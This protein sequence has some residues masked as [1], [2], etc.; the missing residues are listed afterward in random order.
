MSSLFVD[1]HNVVAILE[2]SDAAEGFEQIIDF[3]SGSYIHYALTNQ[4]G[5]LSTHTTRF[6]SLALTQKVFAN[7]R[8]VGKGFLRV[9]TPLFEGMIADRPP[10]EEELGAEQVH[11]DAVVVAVV[12]E[13]VVEDVAHMA[14]PSPPPHGISSPPQE[15]S[16]PPYQPP[17]LPQPQDAEGSSLLFQQVLDICYALA[18]RVEGLENDKA[19]QQLEIVRL[20]ARVKKL[21][22]IHMV[23]SSKFRRLK[24]VGTSQRVESLEDMENVFNQGRIIVD[25]DRDEE[26]ELVADQEKDA[27]V[28]GRHAD[29]QAELYNLD[30]DHSSKVL[31]MQE[32][33]TEVQ[34]AVE[35]VTTA[36]LMT[37]VVTAAATQVVAAS[38]PIP[39]AKP[40]IL[41]IAAAPAVSTRRRKGVVIRD[42]KEELPSN[43]PAENPKVKDKGKRILIEVPKPIK[44]KDQIEMD[45]EYVRKLQEEFNKEHEET[46]K[47]IDWNVAFDHV[48]SKEPQYIKRYHGMKKKPQT[49]SE[50]R[51]NMIFYLKN[52][53]GYKMDFFKGMKYDEI[54]PIFQAKFDA[55]MRFLF[56]SREEMEEEDQEII[57]SIN[58]TPAQK[59]AKR[60]KLSEE[61][62][63]ADDLRK[64][65]EIV[66]D[67]D[68]DVFVE[69]TPLAQKVPVMDYHMVVIDNKPRNQKSVHGLALVKRWKLMTS[70]GVHVITLLTVQ[71]FLLVEK[72]YPL[73]RFTLEQLV[74]VA[75]LQVDEEKLMLPSE[76]K[77]CQSKIDAARLKLKLFKNITAAE[78]ITK[79]MSI[80]KDQQQALDD[81]L[82]PRNHHLRIGNSYKTY[83]DFASRKAIPKLK[84]VW[85]STREK[86]VQAPKASPGQRLKTTTKV[87]KFG[88]KNLHATIPKAKG[89]ETLSEVALSEDEQM[90]IATK[91]SKIQFHSS[92]VS[93]SSH[94]VDTQS[95][96]PDEQQQKTFSQDEEDA[97]EE[98]D[99]NDDSQESKSDNDGDDLIYPNLSTYKVDNEEEEEEKADD[100]DDDSQTFENVPVSIVVKTPASDTTNPQTYIPIIQ[101]LQQTPESTTTITILTTT[102]PD[103][104][105]FAS[106]FQFDQH[107][108]DVMDVAIQLQTNKLREEAYVKN[109]EFL[110]QENKSIN[111]SDIQKNLYHAL[112]ESYNSDKDIITSYGDVVTL[113]RGRDDQDK[114]EE[115]FV[116]SYRGLKK[117]RSR[118]EA[119]LSKVPT[120][121]E[122]KYTSSSKDDDKSQW[123]PSSSSTPDLE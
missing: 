89:L 11:V 82:V 88:K 29:K 52:T 23:K 106:L 27:K 34:E 2:K 56:K 120:H 10:A 119:E 31:S 72:R 99:A 47:N 60:R 9:E 94:R 46:Y 116:G 48:Q 37:E 68:D 74:N 122:S 64:R 38:T 58:E 22:K 51:K 73:S 109:Q 86:T 76:S 112:V 45:A 110:N 93:G 50:V 91:R 104:P 113:K 66:Q 25:M 44:K 96:V 35:I 40:K 118:K 71:L 36:K 102:L 5:D 75:R 77:D 98:T 16:S 79:I 97:D 4:V 19:A 61:A 21:E 8:R 115:P 33:D 95:K 12:V 30:Q 117:R 107:I 55:N 13:D 67:E 20:K 53:K 15:P 90:K 14:N 7:M 59:A 103:I 42:P 83:Y 92:H 43:T 105:N 26:I 62:Q 32:D 123:N 81:A 41:N 69:A 18:C 84:Y 65:L 63:E 6:I 121:K 85:P 100:D 80:T 54:L 1:T 111:R 87:A 28:E 49:E 39:A 114:D 101:P 78:D 57:K 70:C 3:L 108:K 17:Y 24:K